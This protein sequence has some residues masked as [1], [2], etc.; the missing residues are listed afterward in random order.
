FAAKKSDRKFRDERQGR[1]ARGKGERGSGHPAEA[2]AEEEHV[3]RRRVQGDLQHLAVGA[4]GVT[5]EVDGSLP[6]LRLE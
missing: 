6:A 5:G 3:L 4:A 2:A 1:R